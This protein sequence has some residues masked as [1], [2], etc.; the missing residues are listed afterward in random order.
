M[1]RL[2]HSIHLPPLLLA[3][4]LPVQPQRP[5]KLLPLGRIIRLKPM[6]EEYTL[7]P[8]KPL[9][10]LF[11]PRKRQPQDKVRIV[12]LPALLRKLEGSRRVCFESKILLQ[13]I[14]EGTL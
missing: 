11:A 3:N 6:L 1:G 4:R 14:I 13:Q 8:H 12:I 7:N 10:Q 9:P 5:N 2:Q